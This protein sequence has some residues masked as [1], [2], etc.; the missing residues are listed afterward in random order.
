MPCRARDVCTSRPSIGA[1][2]TSMLVC[3]RSKTTCE[4]AMR[5]RFTIG[6]GVLTAAT[7][8]EIGP[9]ER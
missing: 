1:T 9:T 7:S 6:C 8:F 5:G 2:R 3:S 4:S